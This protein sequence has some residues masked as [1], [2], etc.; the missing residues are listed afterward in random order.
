MTDKLVRGV[1]A[2]SYKWICDAAWSMGVPEGVVVAACIRLAK[3]AEQHDEHALVHAVESEC[4]ARR[5][6]AR[7]A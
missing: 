2:A 4:A 3:L 1:D 7:Q 6:K 5:E